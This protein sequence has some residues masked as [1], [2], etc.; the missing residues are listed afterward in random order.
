MSS[1]MYHILTVLACALA[2][3]TSVITAIFLHDLVHGVIRR[4]SDYKFGLPGWMQESWLAVPVATAG[5]AATAF[6]MVSTVP[7]HVTI[8]QCGS[9]NTPTVACL[10]GK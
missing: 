1:C 8:V 7:K 5:V 9:A 10:C 2:I 4:L 6:L 3:P